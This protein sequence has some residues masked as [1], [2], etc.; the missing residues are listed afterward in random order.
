MYTYSLFD[1]KFLEMLS[2]NVNALSLC[3]LSSPSLFNESNNFY[4]ISVMSCA[5][6]L[7]AFMFEIL[8]NIFK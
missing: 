1:S 2:K 6:A 8:P 4:E 5:T 7:C 3:Y